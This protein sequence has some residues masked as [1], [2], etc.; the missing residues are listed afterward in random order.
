MYPI[1]PFSLLS[2]IYFGANYFENPTSHQKPRT[3]SRTPSQVIQLTP[4]GSTTPTHGPTHVIPLDFSHVSYTNEVPVLETPPGYFNPYLNGFPP[5]Q[6]PGAHTTNSNNPDPTQNLSREG[7]M[8]QTMQGMSSSSSNQP[9]VQFSPSAFYPPPP[10][11]FNSNPH[12]G[13]YLPPNYTP[14]TLLQQH[15]PSALTLQNPP[16]S[17]LLSQDEMNK[18]LRKSK[19]EKKKSYKQ[20][21]LLT[22]SNASSTTNSSNMALVN[23]KKKKR[24]RRRSK[25]LNLPRKRSRQKQQEM[26]KRKREQEEEERLSSLFNI[27]PPSSSSF[28]GLRSLVSTSSP[29][30]EF[31]TNVPFQFS[32]PHNESGSSPSFSTISPPPQIE[33]EE[34][35]EEIDGGRGRRRGRRG[36]RENS[37]MSDYVERNKHKEEEEEEDEETDEISSF[38]DVSTQSSTFYTPNPHLHSPYP[39]PTTTTIQSIHTPPPPP[40]LLASIMHPRV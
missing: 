10:H 32:F 17:A 26:K 13:Y 6:H 23:G 25:R 39:A 21:V 31:S 15:N 34:E 14:T 40:L 20:D 3:P 37:S 18:N 1:T 24:K 9:F 28:S 33:E 27:S 35:E 7:I 30:S 4:S 8:R 16:P 19:S 5:P 22:D 36:K 2:P 29:S 38:D 11:V 12:A